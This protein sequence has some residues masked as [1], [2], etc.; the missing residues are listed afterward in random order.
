MTKCNRWALALVL[1]AMPLVAAAQM[2]IRDDLNRPVHL[3]KKPER[4]VTL[5]PF[6][7]E[8]VYAAGAG[9]YVIGVSKLSDFP[10]DARK[11]S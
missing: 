3:K 4:I 6:L 1:A 2:S 7:T 8:L 5:A 9:E 10:P 11:V